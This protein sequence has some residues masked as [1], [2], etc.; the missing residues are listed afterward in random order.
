MRLFVRPAGK[1]AASP[2]RKHGGDA[3]P[4]RPPHRIVKRITAWRGRGWRQRC[5][6]TRFELRGSQGRKVCCKRRRHRPGT[7]PEL[8]APLRRRAKSSPEFPLEAFRANSLSS[9]QPPAQRLSTKTFPDTYRFQ[10]APLFRSP[11]E[12]LGSSTYAASS[13]RPP[14]KNGRRRPQLFTTPLIYVSA[15]PRFRPHPKKRGRLKA[16]G[17]LSHI[18]HFLYLRNDRRPFLF[19][20]FPPLPL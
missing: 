13:A 2:A 5:R 4:P 3:V 10:A 7:C 8:T 12:G 16:K 6:L 19:P 14:Q 20:F 11:R 15:R 1:A 17:S 9:L 18:P